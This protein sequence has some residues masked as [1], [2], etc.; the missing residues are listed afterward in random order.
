M[1][2]DK[3]VTSTGTFLRI[4]GVI[5]LIT[6]CSIAQAQIAVNMNVNA[7]ED[8]LTITTPGNCTNGANSTGCVKAQGRQPIN[9][10]LTG[11]KRCSEGGNWALD[12]VALGMSEGSTGNLTD[13]AASDFN[14]DQSSGEVTP[15]SS[16]A[17]Q[18][19]I[20]NNNTAVYDVWYTVYASCGDSVIDTDP[21]IEND[22]GGHR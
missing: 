5:L 1:K 14:A 7:S 16:S 3:R 10:N 19:Q 11:S 8:K 2:M 6:C 15:N 21:R 4:T 12:H 13:D 18:I 22:G 20:R 9:F 17:N